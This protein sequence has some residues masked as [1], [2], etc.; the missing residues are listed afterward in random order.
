VKILMRET[1]ELSKQ[2]STTLAIR[3]LYQQIGVMFG[4]H[5]REYDN[6]L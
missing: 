4:E 6:F 3:H 5:S 2:G 1:A